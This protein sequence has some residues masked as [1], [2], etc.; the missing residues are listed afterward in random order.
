MLDV[1]S[2]GGP[3]VPAAADDRRLRVIVEIVFIG[4]V[5]LLVLDIAVRALAPRLEPPLEWYSPAA[6]RTVEEMD[7]LQEAQVTSDLVFV[8][9]SMVQHGID[10]GRARAAVDE[11]PWVHKA[12]LPA[13]QTPVIERWLLEEIVPRLQPDR[14]VWGISSLD[15]NGN[16]ARPTIDV[17][18]QAR[19]ARPG[20]MGGID[21]ALSRVSYLSRYRAQLRDPVELS[22]ALRRPSAGEDAEHPGPLPELLTSFA[23]DGGRPTA[24]ERRRIENRVL[25]DY[26]VGSRELASLRRTLAEVRELGIDVALVAMPVPDRYVRA[27]PR[28]TAD[29]EDHLTALRAVADEYDVQLVDASRWYEDDDFED[30]TH[31]FRDAADR[32][33]QRLV[34]ELRREGFVP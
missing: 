30:F 24:R 23:G 14:V 18:E 9:T 25:V 6:A 2:T 26:E 12:P 8:G 20:P 17:Y 27:H 5:T 19:A 16:R 10:P 4:L 22:R 34:D 7:L 3:T 32:F 15:L 1:R 33:T 21:R 31:L 28:G 11:L 29:F 13:A